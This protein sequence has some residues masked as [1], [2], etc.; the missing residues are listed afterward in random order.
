[1]TRR[2]SA[3][4]PRI[5]AVGHI[6]ADKLFFSVYGLE[7]TDKC[8]SGNCR[9]FTFNKLTVFRFKH[10]RLFTARIIYS[11]CKRVRLAVVCFL[12]SVFMVNPA[13]RLT[14][15]RHIGKRISVFKLLS[16]RVVKFGLCRSCFRFIINR[17]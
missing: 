15:S 14:V 17:D 13:L 9:C 5:E 2:Y 4:L 16:V 7:P 12:N 10:L 6:S 8:F 1:M 3:I 11:Y